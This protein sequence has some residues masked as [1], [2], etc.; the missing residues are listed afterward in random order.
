MSELIWILFGFASQIKKLSLACCPLLSDRA[1]LQERREDG[2]QKGKFKK[3]WDVDIEAAKHKGQ[4]A[5]LR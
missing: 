5:G 1:E 3:R 4:R 2:L